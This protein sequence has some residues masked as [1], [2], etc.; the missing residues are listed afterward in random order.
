MRAR[1]FLAREKPG[2]FKNDVDPERAP[3]QLGGIALRDH[4][5][6]TTVHHHRVTIDFDG[7]LELA[8]RGVVTREMRV[9][10]GVSE[11]VQRDYLDRVLLAALV[12]STQDVAADSAVTVNRDFDGHVLLRKCHLG[13]GPA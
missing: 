11:I 9:R 8:M 10:L 6:A 4:F 3:R 2:A 13:T 5:D 1:F 12:M 7:P